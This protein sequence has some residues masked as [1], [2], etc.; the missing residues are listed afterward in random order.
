MYDQYFYSS[1][2]NFNKSY[3]FI[4]LL[5]QISDFAFSSVD[6]HSKFSGMIFLIYFNYFLL[7]FS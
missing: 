5:Y 7:S 3:G 4:E 6:S 2:F 1:V